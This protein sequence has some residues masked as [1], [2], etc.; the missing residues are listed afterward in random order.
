M[1]LFDIKCSFISTEKP[2]AKFYFSRN[3]TLIELLTVIAIISILAALLFP[4]LGHA[5]QS[6]KCAKWRAHSKLVRG[7]NSLLA[8]YSFEDGNGAQTLKNISVGNGV[9]N[10]YS[11]KD[12]N[13]KMMGNLKITTDGTASRWRNK[14]GVMFNGKDYIDIAHFRYLSTWNSNLPFS[15]M[16]WTKITAGDMKRGFLF[17]SLKDA[18]QNKYRLGSYGNYRKQRLIFKYGTKAGRIV[19]KFKNYFDKWVCIT[20][21]SEGKDGHFKGVFINGKLISYGTKSAAPEKGITQLMLGGAPNRKKYLKGA[22]DE[23]AFYSRVLTQQEIN[24]HYENGKP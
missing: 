9:N 20:M 18:A 7:D 8:Y 22:I 1:L 23:M 6:A 14:G 12:Y 17:G 24:A 19:V 4:V 15:I 10:E 5:R 16:Y 13:G 11:A 2:S 21:V 3:F